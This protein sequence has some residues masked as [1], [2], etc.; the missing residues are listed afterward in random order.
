MAIAGVAALLCLT[1]LGCKR[2]AAPATPGAL[3]PIPTVTVASVVQKDVPIYEGSVGSTVGFVDANILPK[4][5]G[6]LLKQDYQDGSPVRAGQLLFE[7]DARQYQAALDQA[8]GNLA[9]ARAQLKQNQLTLAR[10]TELLQKSVIARQAFDDITQS[11][12]ASEALVKA[13]EAAVESARLN[14]QWTKVYSPISGV[15]G[16]AQAQV[17]D[18]VGPSTLLTTVSQ[19]D[20]IK[21]SFPV[22]EKLYLRFAGQI[23]ASG[24][25]NARSSP[26]P[27]ELI[28]DNGSVYSFPGRLHAV[29]RQVD[30]QTGTIMMQATFPNPEN[31]L[32]PGMYAKVR[33]Q[34]DVQ[35]NALLVPQTAVSSIQGQYQVAVVG[36][37]N[38]VTLRPVTPGQK[39]GSFWVIDGGLKPRE[40]VVVDGA[41]KLQEGMEVR[42]V[43]ATQQTPRLS[44]SPAAGANPVTEE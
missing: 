35:H 3:P 27:I 38:K 19:V 9:Q 4:V 7:I 32:R 12:R 29:N 8:L 1:A 42:P 34:T 43:L 2:A 13:D 30:V 10:D 44:G 40:R 36:A 31:I 28:L 5:S 16:I 41:Q 26:P 22:S 39:T 21:V 20:P 11:T 33:A 23:N 17:G 25:Q 15:A 18:L 24:T 6:Y 14:L 37:D